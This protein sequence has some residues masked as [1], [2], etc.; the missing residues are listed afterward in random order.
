MENKRKLLNIL[1]I[2]C[3]IIQMSCI[4]AVIM[5]DNASIDT[6][7]IVFQLIAVI[8]QIYIGNYILKLRK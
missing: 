6:Y 8:A 4:T 2:V 7:I 3:I 5:C 1:T